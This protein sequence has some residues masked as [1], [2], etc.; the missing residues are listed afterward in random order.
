MSMFIPEVIGISNTSSI[1]FNILGGEFILFTLNPILAKLIQCVIFV[2]LSLFFMNMGTKLQIIPLRSEIP[3]IVSI[4]IFSCVDYVHYFSN[5][6]VAFILFAL[7]IRQLLLMYN[8]ESQYTG[9]FNIAFLMTLA[10]IFQPEYIL[11]APLFI[12]GFV[13][14]STF[15]LRAFLA[16]LCGIILVLFILFTS[17]FITDNISILTDS[18]FEIHCYKFEHLDYLRSDLIFTASLLIIA[19]IAF[20]SYFTFSSNHKLNVRVNFRLINTG[21]IYTYIWLVM[22]YQLSST[23]LLV[24]SIFLIYLLSLYFSTSTNKVSNITFCCFIVFCLSYRI[25]W[26]LGY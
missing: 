8:R 22:L 9:A 23:S 19:L 5:Q 3:L 26:L 24:S 11:L 15:T 12:I 21:Y 16:F 13:I 10:S 25:F 6:T 14:F 20:V 18:V 17:F 1:N 7:S 4:L 2:L